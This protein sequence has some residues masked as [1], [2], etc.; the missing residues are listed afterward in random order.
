MVG[1]CRLGRDAIDNNGSLYS[2]DVSNQSTLMFVPNTGSY[3]TSP[4][5][6]KSFRFASFTSA[7]KS[8][9]PQNR[10]RPTN[11]FHDNYTIYLETSSLVLSKASRKMWTITRAVRLMSSVHGTTMAVRTG[12]K[13]ADDVARATI[14]SPKYFPAFLACSMT[15][16][17]IAGYNCMEGLRRRRHVQVRTN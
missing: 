4:L 8:F 13:T 2:N 1:W 9:Q 15:I 14:F 12:E 7:Q 3:C 16:S 10:Q 17:G 5:H 6:R 11:E